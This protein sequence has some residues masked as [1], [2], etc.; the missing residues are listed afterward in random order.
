[1]ALPTA[2]LVLVTL[3]LLGTAAVFTSATELSIAGNGRQELEALSVAEA[4]V[5]ESL[6]RLNVKD[7]TV[8]ARIVP[9][10]DPVTG[11][12]IAGWS[13]TIVNKNALG[14][15]EVQT[16]TG[17][18]GTASAL[19][20]STRVQYKIEAVEQ[21]INHCNANGCGDAIN[22]PEVV[23]FN[24]AFGYA[25]TK[26]PSGIPP[27]G[28][29]TAGPPV[30]Q[31]VS[32]YTDAASG[33]TKTLRV[34]ATRTLSNARF[35]ATVRACGTIHIGAGGSGTTTIDATNL[36]PSQVPITGASGVP[37]DAGTNVTPPGNVQ[38]NQG[39]CPPDLFEQTFGMT[40]NDLKAIADTVTSSSTMPPD[41]TKG[42]I[43]Y[44]TGQG[45]WQGSGT[46]GSAEEPVIA[47]FE[48]SFQLQTATC[49]C[50]IFAT[51]QVEL[52]NNAVVQGAIVGVGTGAFAFPSQDAN[53][54]IHGGSRVI[55]NPDVVSNLTRSSP[56]ATILWRVN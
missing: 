16:L 46:I 47:I 3:T 51:G 11:A 2:L 52:N 35:T 18:F 27:T 23:R 24:T 22:P 45:N 29:P 1:M 34:E 30:V 37:I 38:A 4:G 50:I 28:S 15:T 49:Y 12:P 41:G 56:F 53:T 20:V 36:Q 43:I 19:Q 9:D 14:A 7:T 44:V 8:A 17:A 31:L 54:H 5:H 6:A 25:G 39:L 32:T 13:R 21:P 40:P 26:V 55:Y 42:K 48:G 10:A 33:A